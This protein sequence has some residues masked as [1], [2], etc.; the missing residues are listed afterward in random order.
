MPVIKEGSRGKAVKIW[1]IIVGV[2]A[3]GI[4]G[5]ATETATKAFQKKVGIA[6][7]GIVGKNSWRYG[8]ESV[9]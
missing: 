5:Q 2:N 9:G 3:D 6:Q 8:L 1:Q 4:F 7:D